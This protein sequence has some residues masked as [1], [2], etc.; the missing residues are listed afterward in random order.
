MCLG[1]G[2]RGRWVLLQT[3][4]YAGDPP[5]W[6][7]RESDALANLGTSWAEPTAV[8]SR[9]RWS[10]DDAELGQFRTKSVTAPSC[11]A[12]LPRRGR[13]NHHSHTAASQ[14][15]P[16]TAQR[17]PQDHRGFEHFQICTLNCGQWTIDI[18]LLTGPDPG[19]EDSCHGCPMGRSPAAQGPASTSQAANKGWVCRGCEGEKVVLAALCPRIQPSGPSFALG[20]ALPITWKG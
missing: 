3:R 6:S 13:L 4:T 8:M 5:C 12:F 20:V 18:V 2:R 11:F 1:E 9:R 10:T 19:Q 7:R 16:A 14:P 17:G 15:C